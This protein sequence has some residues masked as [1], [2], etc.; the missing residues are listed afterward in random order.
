[1]YLAVV[2]W[3]RVEFGGHVGHGTREYVG[4]L[5][6]VRERLLTHRDVLRR[7]P[8]KGRTTFQVQ[9]DRIGT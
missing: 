7:A 2:F 4:E 9:V 1:M 5:L 3:L 6:D 8:L